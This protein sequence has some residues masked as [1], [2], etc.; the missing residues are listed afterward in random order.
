MYDP[1][2]VLQK[3]STSLGRSAPAT[4]AP[5][6]PEIPEHVARL[7]SSDIGLPEL[8]AKHAAELKMLVEIISIDDL[9]ESHATFLTQTKCQKIMLTDTPLIQSLDIGHQLLKKG[10]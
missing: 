5:V 9:V 2:H 10:F 7:V 6:P 4:E 1:K 8:F 3:I